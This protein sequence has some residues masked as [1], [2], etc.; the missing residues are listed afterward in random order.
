MHRK[1]FLLVTTFIF[2]NLL[3]KVL[4]IYHRVFLS[5]P[6][7]FFRVL[8]NARG[9]IFTSRSGS[10]IPTFTTRWQIVMVLSALRYGT[11][12][13]ISNDRFCWIDI[14][15]RWFEDW[16]LPTTAYGSNSFSSSLLD[17]FQ[18][19]CFEQEAPVRFER[20]APAL[21]FLPKISHFEMNLT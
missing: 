5:V 21:Q 17:M 20:T 8:S 15:I 19:S 12:F 6:K 9:C 4:R 14:F 2:W 1:M 13:D 7:I 16:Q 10:S 18:L 11:D 3:L